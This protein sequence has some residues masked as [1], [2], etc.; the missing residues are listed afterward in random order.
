[1]CIYSP[2]S[3]LPCFTVTG[4]PGVPVTPTGPTAIAA[5]VAAR[6]SLSTGQIH[7]SPTNPG[8]TGAASWFWLDPPPTTQQLSLTLAG[9]AVTVTAIP[10]VRWSFG[11]GATHDGGV[12]VPYRPG[13]PPEAAVT[14]VYGTRCLTGDQ[15]RDPYVLA[16]CGSDGYQ[17]IAAVTW[18]I[19]Y[20]A[21]GPVAAAGTLPTRTTTSFTAY[22]VSEAR[23][24][25][26]P[27]AAG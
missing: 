26:V 5:R 24:F 2:G 25:L 19:S 27:G 21:T 14:H 3:A 4:A 1:V 20:R 8:L 23:A 6:L 10:V 11:D 16:S 13:A 15:G 9:E 12:G 7:E 17:L 18:Q 22:P